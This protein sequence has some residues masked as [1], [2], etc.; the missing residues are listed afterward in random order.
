[1]VPV[2]ESVKEHLVRGKGEGNGV[3][4]GCEEETGKGDN[5]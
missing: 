4:R 1:M 2:G 5:F 3:R